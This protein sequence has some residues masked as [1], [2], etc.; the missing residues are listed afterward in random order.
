MPS[1]AHC[2]HIVFTPQ[3]AKQ[4]EGWADKYPGDYE[5]SMMGVRVIV[6]KDAAEIRRIL[7]LRPSSFRRGLSPVSS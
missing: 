2:V 6:V 4:M 7:S 1:S 5:I 3:W